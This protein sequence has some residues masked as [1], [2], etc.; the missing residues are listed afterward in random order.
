MEKRQQQLSLPSRQKSAL[1]SSWTFVYTSLLLV[2]CSWLVQVQA[3]ASPRCPHSLSSYHH[4]HQQRQHQPVFDLHVAKSGGTGGNDPA[5]II[6]KRIY[7]EGDVDG[8]Y[9][10]SCV[11]NEVGE[12]ILSYLILSFTFRNENDERRKYYDV[13]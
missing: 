10:R 4:H 12:S 9:Y 8:G 5:E 1:L 2:S 13:I 6:A 11:R 7:L 3:F